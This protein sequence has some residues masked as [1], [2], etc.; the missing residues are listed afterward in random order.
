M[1]TTYFWTPFILMYFLAQA[2]GCELVYCDYPYYALQDSGNTSWIVSEE[3]NRIY[4]RPESII[5][6]NN[7]IDIIVD[8][9]NISISSIHCDSKG[10]YMCTESFLWWKCCKCLYLNSPLSNT[11]QQC[12]RQKC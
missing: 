1:K 8:E 2:E 4:I 5:L 10:Y 3:G 11:C 9:T 12:L 7:K 6:R